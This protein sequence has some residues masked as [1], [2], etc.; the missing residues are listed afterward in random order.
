VKEFID[1]L[2]PIKKIYEGL[3]TSLTMKNITDISK[4]IESIRN[5]IF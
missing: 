2:E 4:A 3:T 5:Q 1:K